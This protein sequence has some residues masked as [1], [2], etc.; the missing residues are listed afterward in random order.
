M[1]SARPMIFP[2][3]GTRQ[4]VE[5]SSEKTIGDETVELTYHDSKVEPARVQVAPNRTKLYSCELKPG[6]RFP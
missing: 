4:C 6:Y 3:A 2:R 1:G 5:R